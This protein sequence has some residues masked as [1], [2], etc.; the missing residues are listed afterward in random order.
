MIFGELN[1]DPTYEATTIGKEEFE[2]LWVARAGAQ[3]MTPFP[4]RDD[5]DAS[6]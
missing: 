3:P 1:S 2:R 6:T 5:E 4:L